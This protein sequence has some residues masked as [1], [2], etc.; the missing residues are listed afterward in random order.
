[1]KPP[2]ISSVASTIG[3]SEFTYS[4]ALERTRAASTEWLV[5]KRKHPATMAPRYKEKYAAVEGSS[6][7]VSSTRRDI[8]VG[9]LATPI[10]SGVLKKY[11]YR[12]K[13]I[14]KFRSVVGSRCLIK[15]ARVAVGT[16]RRHNRC[17]QRRNLHCREP[18]GQTLLSNRVASARHS[19]QRYRDY[20]T[21]IS[22]R[23]TNTFH[24]GV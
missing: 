6:H 4:E 14:K 19:W 15:S 24:P 9:N 18:Q 21:I 5:V 7:R 3:R 20:T 11:A 17:C 23:E 12:G 16:V 13:R 22:R 2:S 1:M 10:V 8:K